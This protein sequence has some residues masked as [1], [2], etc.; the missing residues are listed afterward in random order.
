MPHTPAAM[1]G[2]PASTLPLAGRGPPTSRGPEPGPGGPCVRVGRGGMGGAALGLMRGG[3][4]GLCRS[5]NGIGPDGATALGAGLEKLTGLETLD[6]RW[7]WPR[8]AG[9]RGD[10]GGRVWARA[11][12]QVQ[13]RVPSVGGGARR[14]RREAPISMPPAEA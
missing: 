2:S 5:N 4:V 8:G 9:T 1:P 13:K 6:L 10:G 7:A 3:G 11:G 12:G 14:G